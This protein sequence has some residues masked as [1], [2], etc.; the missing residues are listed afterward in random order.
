M[1]D[2]DTI[3]IGRVA[4]A[5]G[6]R[7]QVIVNSDTDFPDQRFREGAELL[8]VRS[9]EPPT[10]R[11]I[12]TVRFHQGRPIIAFEGI[13]T[14]NEAEALAGAELKVPAADAGRLPEDT[15]YHYELIGCEVRDRSGKA[16]GSVTGVEGTMEMS[17]LV[18]A[19]S[20]GEVLIPLV[21]EICTEIDVRG[22][23]IVVSPPDGLLE[24]NEPGGRP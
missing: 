5:H 2:D 7:G 13:E 17:R 10:R 16:I 21:A 4:R 11:R 19:G 18:I 8:L 1:A 24:L 23:R 22:R 20:H 3:L 12:A 14:M 9:G 15:Y 6:I